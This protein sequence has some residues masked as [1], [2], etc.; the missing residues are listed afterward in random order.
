MTSV[1]HATGGDGHT[2]LTGQR[3]LGGT[4][5]LGEVIREG[6]LGFA[7]AIGLLSVHDE[8]P[9]IEADTPN[10]PQSPSQPRQA[11]SDAPLSDPRHHKQRAVAADER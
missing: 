9:P 8:A 4:V 7:S 11:L 10:P 2:C 6:L 5:G 1:R 3:R